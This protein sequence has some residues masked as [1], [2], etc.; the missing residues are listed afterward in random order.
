MTPYG[1]ARID[2]AKRSGR[3]KAEIPPVIEL[4]VP[5]DLS[6]ALASQPAAKCFFESLAPT[7]RKQFIGWIGSAKRPETRAKRLKESIVLLAEGE[8]LGLR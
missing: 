1:Q 3:W 8:K 7:Y 6:E 4:D 5:S 2:A